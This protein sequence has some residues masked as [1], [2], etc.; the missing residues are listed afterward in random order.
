MGINGNPKKYSINP[1]IDRKRKIK[2]RQSK[3]K[4]TRAR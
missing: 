2:N 3:Q 1:K 4:A